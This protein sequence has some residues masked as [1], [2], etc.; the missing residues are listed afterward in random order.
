[1]VWKLLFAVFLVLLIVWL[2]MYDERTKKQIVELKDR[3]ANLAQ[4]VPAAMPAP[5][6]AP[7]ATIPE[8]APAP[9]KEGFCPKL[10]QKYGFCDAGAQ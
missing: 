3:A 7:A 4:S 8:P 6:P 9:K 10:G 2:V 5:A 1:M